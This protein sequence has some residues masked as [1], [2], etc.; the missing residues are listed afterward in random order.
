MEAFSSPRPTPYFFPE[1]QTFS[2]KKVGLQL[3]FR[4]FVQPLSAVKTD[5]D[6]LEKKVQRQAVGIIFRNKLLKG[7]W[8]CKRGLTYYTDVDS[9]V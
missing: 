7:T 1:P 4:S 5:I 3:P 9:W 6:K 8:L 2:T